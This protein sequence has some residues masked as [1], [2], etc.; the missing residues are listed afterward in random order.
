M[1]RSP[2]WS[3]REGTGDTMLEYVLTDNA[4]RDAN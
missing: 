3:M 2:L 1:P 4:G